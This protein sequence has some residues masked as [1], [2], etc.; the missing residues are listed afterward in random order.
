MPDIQYETF[1]PEY[2][3]D[4]RVTRIGGAD[5]KPLSKQ[6]NSIR[7]EQSPSGTVYYRLDA[8]GNVPQVRELLERAGYPIQNIDISNGSI[9]LR[10]APVDPA[11]IV[12][13][14]PI[15]ETRLLGSDDLRPLL[16]TL[17][18]DIELGRGESLYGVL[19]SQTVNA[20]VDRDMNV[21]GI[22]PSQA[23]IVKIDRLEYDIERYGDNG[24]RATVDAQLPDGPVS[25]LSEDVLPAAVGDRHVAEVSTQID[26][27]DSHDA[28]T[29]RASLEK[30]GIKTQLHRSPDVVNVTEGR[31][32]N[33]ALE[34][35]LKE[36]GIEFRHAANSSSWKFNSPEDADVAGALMR[37]AQPAV[38]FDV[39]TPQVHVTAAAPADEVAIALGKSGHIQNAIAN[40]IAETALE[41]HPDQAITNKTIREA[42]PRMASTPDVPEAKSPNPA[43]QEMR[44]R[45]EAQGRGRAAPGMASPRSFGRNGMSGRMHMEARDMHAPLRPLPSARAESVPSITE[46]DVSDVR[47]TLSPEGKDLIAQEQ[48]RATMPPE[49]TSP[50]D[51][52][53]PDGRANNLRE[54]FN[55]R[56]EF[57]QPQVQERRQLAKEIE[58]FEAVQAEK[59]LPAEEIRRR[60]AEF[61]GSTPSE[62]PT[63]TRASRSM[64]DIVA[65]AEIDPAAARLFDQMQRS[66]A[67]PVPDMPARVP[68]PANDTGIGLLS[69]ADDVP[70]DLSTGRAI[71]ALEKFDIHMPKR[72]HVKGGLIGAAI[73]VGITATIG[74]AVG[75]ATRS[76][77]EDVI[78]AGANG[79]LEATKQM[80]G[81]NDFKA[82]DNLRGAAAVVDTATGG[83]FVQAVDADRENQR[84]LAVPQDKI[85][86]LIASIRPD[87]KA[88]TGNP[89]LD[90]LG[91][92]LD[93]K[94]RGL[95]QVHV[96]T[97]GG[98]LQ[99][100]TGTIMVDGYLIGY[101]V[102]IDQKIREEA[103]IFLGNGG[104]LQQAQMALDPEFRN[105][106]KASAV[107]DLAPIAST[108]GAYEPRDPNLRRIEALKTETYRIG[109]DPQRQI[110]LHSEMMSAARAYIDSG[111]TLKDARFDYFRT[112][113]VI[114]ENIGSDLEAMGK[115]KQFDL[116]KDGKIALDE[117]VQVMQKAGVT[118]MPDYDKDEMTGAR[119]V[120]TAIARAESKGNTR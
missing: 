114:E 113:I 91:V 68:T 51:R 34:T 56:G 73:D 3:G 104:T 63:R 75:I 27:R 39:P 84:R 79:A 11:T 32:D 105:N 29:V 46:A 92:L 18:T 48:Q 23:G 95:T 87:A 64:H 111:K 85:S 40:E 58:Q 86:E 52:Y 82:G 62:I 43:L 57:V 8:T 47:S 37:K 88:S 20:I 70:I 19:D 109:N 25:R 94:R 44:Y 78:S 49:V 74:T 42:A 55:A 36:R 106:A 107:L 112:A 72:P 59:Q 4:D 97:D 5:D 76:N 98:R 89:Q 1:E 100:P 30:S 6:L 17:S 7:M 108:R 115:K 65:R 14:K 90:N 103:G 53:A 118:S 24:I 12:P 69:K 66:A 99:E 83:A 15:P 61:V 26:L 16:K 50:N 31:A 110:E 21:R 33:A 28:N 80:V 67:I 71:S 93:M 119:D 96:P 81:Y 13:G 60:N 38:K 101:D 9:L 2:K 35:M 10:R 54:G 102:P 45:L 22:K 120:V 77:D 116:N 41:A 117:I